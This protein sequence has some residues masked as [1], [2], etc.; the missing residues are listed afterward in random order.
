MP[1]MR[2]RRSVAAVIC[3]GLVQSAAGTAWGDDLLTPSSFTPIA[4][5]LTEWGNYAINTSGSTP[6]I[7]LPDGTVLNGVVDASGQ[8][9]VFTFGSVD[10]VGN[11]LTSISVVG[12]R[13]VAI[14]SQGNLTIGSNGSTYGVV[15][16]NL[17]ATTDAY[18]FPVAGPGGSIFGPGAGQ[19]GGLGG[20]G[21]GGYG[22]AGGG[23]GPGY[24]YNLGWSFPGGP[25]GSAYGLTKFGL[26]GGSGGGDGP[27]GYWGAGGGA[28]EL[29]AAGAVSVNMSIIA[30]GGNG[31]AT[32]GGGSGGEVAFLGQSI[33]MNSSYIEATGGNGGGSGSAGGYDSKYYGQGGGGGGGLVEFDAPT[34]NLGYAR[35]DLA[36]GG[37]GGA[38]AGNGAGGRGLGASV[39]EPSSLLMTGLAGVVG[40]GI[41]IRRRLRGVSRV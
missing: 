35:F 10:M 6:T 2:A 38:G 12:D 25:G 5:S 36:G 40:L 24:D 19:D 22:G 8:T 11:G 14:L 29:G 15:S 17:S 9:A 20:G 21:G 30:D 28:V 37:G 41:A 16:M 18:G 7:T 27:L 39:P 33:S 34:I 3:L 32:A 4:S 13:A 26:Q 23:G 1:G 31:Q